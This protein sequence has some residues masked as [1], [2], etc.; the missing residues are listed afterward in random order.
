M[1]DEPEGRVPRS[2]DA[3]S[4]STLGALALVLL[5]LSALV[6]LPRV[7]HLSGA[8]SVGRDAPDFVLPLVA[9]GSE[10][11]QEG[12]LRLSNLRGRVVLIDFWA[13]WCE[14]CRLQ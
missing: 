5:L 7:L 11:G 1:I 12:M 9:N 8:T 14:P 6:L 2:A 4:R 10:L 13:T 3:D